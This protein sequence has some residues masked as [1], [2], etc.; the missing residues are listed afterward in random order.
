MPFEGLDMRLVDDAKIAAGLA[1]AF[2]V[3][4]AS[5]VPLLL[6]AL[7]PE[8]QKLPLPLPVFCALL[9]LQMT[10]VYGLLGLAGLRLARGQSLPVT[11][12]SGRGMLVAIAAG[13]LCGTLL[14]AIVGGVQRLFPGTLPRTLHP[15]GF[16]AA[17]VASI[18]GCLGEEILFRLL[19]LSLLV[20]LVPRRRMGTIAAITISAL[21]FGAAHAPALVLLFGD[22][23]QVP[24]LAWVWLIALNG[25]C[26]VTFGMIYLRHGV[27]A[28]IAAHLCHRSGV[29]RGESIIPRLRCSAVRAPERGCHRRGQ[30]TTSRRPCRRRCKRIA[31]IRRRRRNRPR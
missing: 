25:L 16:G 21:A 31:P 20:W 13:L 11:N 8:S 17:L 10:V 18:A 7:P 3:A 30:P 6:V 4:A 2:G 23:S 27:F 1:G 15:A 5:A 12:W 29:A 9:A 26:G 28:A 24:P 14:V 22:L 19:G